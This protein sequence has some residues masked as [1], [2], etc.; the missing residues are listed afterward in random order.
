MKCNLK[1]KIQNYYRKN[2]KIILIIAFII[3]TILS[4]L[5]RIPGMDFESDDFIAPIN[6]W[7][8]YLR[9][10]GGILGVGDIIGEYNVPYMV[11][12]AILSYIPLSNLLLVK[13][14]SFL[15]DYIMAIGMAVLTTK[16]LGKEKKLSALLAYTLTIFLPTVVLNSS[17]WA[18]CDSIYT[19]FVIWSL[20]Y[21]VDKKYLPSFILLGIACAFK[22]QFIFIL[23][24]YV[25]VA[26]SQWKEFPWYNF[27][28]IIIADFVLCLPV[29]LTRTASIAECMLI[30][31]RQT[32]RYSNRISLNFPGFYN[33]ILNP[34]NSDN[35]IYN[36]PTWLPKLMVVITLSIFAITALIVLVK[37][38]KFSKKDIINI[39]IW[40]VLVSTFFLPYMHER[41]IYMAEVLSI[42]YLIMYGI[43]RSYVAVLL[44]VCSICTYMLFL[45]KI[46]IVP[47]QILSCINLL[48][49]ICLTIDI[50]CEIKGR[51]I[52]P[53]I[54][55][56]QNDEISKKEL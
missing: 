54:M 46:N 15:F 5:I 11:L 29:I 4:V 33:L 53:K 3:I 14:S 49:I 25:L 16:I 1:E 47:I 48:A 12:M 8:N 50:F 40:S 51:L 23:P 28:W 17:V 24:I 19:A 52:H 56:K 45:Y 35:V 13:I 22:L 9:E 55:E 39:G 30:Y 34:D 21:L 27:G 26:L 41:Y 10:N 6:R 38:I 7:I 32:G 2:E 44:Q 20:V 42:I 36:F 43:K 31:V 18:Q 37:K